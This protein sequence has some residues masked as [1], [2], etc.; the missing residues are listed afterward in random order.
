MS[1]RMRGECLPCSL[2]QTDQQRGPID[3][4]APHRRFSRREASERLL[5]SN[6]TPRVCRKEF[7]GYLPVTKSDV[8]ASPIGDDD[9]GRSFDLN[10]TRRERAQ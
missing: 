3:I 6:T 9:A 10:Q 4:D 8:G 1:S 5:Q 7:D 2:Q